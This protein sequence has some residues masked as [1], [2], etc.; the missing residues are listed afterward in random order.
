MWSVPLASLAVA[1]TSQWHT[2]LWRDI[3]IAPGSQLATYDYG[4]WFWVLT[5]DHYVLMAV[6]TVVLLAASRRVA[7]PFRVPLLAVVAAVVLP[8]IGNVAYVF[9]LGPK[10]PLN[11]LSISVIASGSI[12]AWIVGREGLFDPLPRARDAILERIADGVL[13]VGPTGTVLHGAGA[14]RWLDVSADIV[15]GRWNEPVGQVFVIRDVSSRKAA[16]HERETLIAHL[17]HALGH[18]QT[19]EGLLPICAHCKRIREET[20][21]WASVEDFLT[22]R[23]PVEFSHGIC[24]ECMRTLYEEK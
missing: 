5:A 13:V 1:W 22:R 19:L 3:T 2:W 21:G 9:K 4:W 20:G 7:G 8:W 11:W 10:P 6:A 15:R 12:F 24:P 14:E 23:A 17:E 16:E 18:I